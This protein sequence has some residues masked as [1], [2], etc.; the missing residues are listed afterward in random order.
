MMGPASS[1]GVAK[2]AV[3]P[4]SF[5]PRAWAWEWEL[6][7]GSLCCKEGNDGERNGTYLV[8][9]FCAHKSRQERVMDIDDVRELSQERIADNLHVLCHHH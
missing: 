7:D 1:S 2:W 4:I 3:A 8:V 5:T 6:V 9:G